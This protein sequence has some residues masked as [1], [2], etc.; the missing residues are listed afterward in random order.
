MVNNLSNAL[1]LSAIGMGLV[2]VS[3]LLLW[4]LMEI[5]VRLTGKLAATE[6]ARADAIE[7]DSAKASVLESIKD[8]R[9]ELKRKAAASAVAVALALQKARTG[10]LPGKG[11]VNTWQTA[12]RAGQLSQRASLFG[13]KVKGR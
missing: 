6:Q 12:Q 11:H 9:M 1:L 3:I 7:E 2:F 8:K 5:L 10:A 13:R 4:G